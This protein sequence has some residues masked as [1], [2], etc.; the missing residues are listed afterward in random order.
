MNT[1]YII[2]ITIVVSI[3]IFFSIMCMTSEKFNTPIDVVY[4]WVDQ[5]D[6]D[7]ETYKNLY[8]IDSDDGNREFSRYNNNKELK[9]SLR[10]IFTHCSEW[11]GTVYIVVKDGQQPDFIDFTNPKIVLVNHSEI[12]PKSVLPTFN[13]NAI[14]LYIH[15]IKKLRNVYVYMNDDLFVTKPFYPVTNGGKIKVNVDISTNP[16]PIFLKGNPKEPYN[17]SKM[18]DNTRYYTKMLL[19]T[20]ANISFPHTPSVCYK[21]WEVEM[22]NILRDNNLLEGTL[23]PFRRNTNIITNQ[24]FRTLFYLTKKN[25]VLKVKWKDN[26]NELKPNNCTIKVKPFIAINLISDE[27]THSFAK[28][29]EKLYPIP[30]PVEKRALFKK[31]IDK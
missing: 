18:Y 31:I 20:N 17:F 16:T 19:N 29:M 15:K 23:T 8:E 6:P 4:T 10:S 22:E 5:Y 7:R 3:I 30:S 13:S 14:E 21:P 25:K 27:C 24:T 28:Q 1:N 12:M 11:I 9:Y 26:V 2:I